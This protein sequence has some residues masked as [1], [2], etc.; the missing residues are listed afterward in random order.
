MEEQSGN[1]HVQVTNVTKALG[2]V[3]RMVTHSNKVVFD[4][5]D[6]GYDRSYMENKVTGDKLCSRERNGVYV[7]DVLVAPP[8]YKGEVDQ[9]GQPRGFERPSGR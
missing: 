6:E 9:Y 3:S 5:D 1:K 7:L 4:I 8:G 2:S